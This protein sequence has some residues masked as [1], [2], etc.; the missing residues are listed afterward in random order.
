MH[1]L[2]RG[3]AHLHDELAGVLATEQHAERTWRVMQAMQDM[4]ALAQPSLAVAR[5]EPGAGFL[6]SIVVAEHLETLHSPTLR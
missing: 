1:R 3:V 4:Q 6:I 2:R 5:G